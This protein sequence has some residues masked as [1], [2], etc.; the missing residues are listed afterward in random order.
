MSL[1]DID[2]WITEFEASER[3]SRD[4]QAQIVYR[5]SQAK[6][7]AEYAKLSAT[8]RI[9]LKQLS[10]ELEQL[11]Q[12]LEQNSVTGKMTVGESKRRKFQLETLQSK[13]IGLETQFRNVDGP[14]SRSQ[15][16][17]GT[18]SLW[19]DD[20]DDVPIINSNPSTNPQ[21]VQSLRQQQIRILD[22]QNQGLESLSKI[23]TRQKDL[24]LKIGDEVDLQNDIIDDLA[25][26]MERTDAR[27]N[28]E[29][30]HVGVVTR[31]DSTWG[32]WLTIIL[33]FVAIII[34]AFL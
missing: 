20:D 1:V 10:G 30:R 34:V 27:V 21:S 14:S 11:D 3:L 22:D 19:D 15:L 28:S 16:L 23:I 17:Q 9:R 6:L 25:V 5:N 18:S 12:K 7:S 31:T 4:V 24:A 29:T 32:Y 8:I 26:D 2:T 13:L 33:L